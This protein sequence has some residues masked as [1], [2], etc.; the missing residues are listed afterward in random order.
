MYQKILKQFN[1]DNNYLR[2]PYLRDKNFEVLRLVIALDKND[3]E[4]AETYKAKPNGNDSGFITYSDRINISAEWLY[5]SGYIMT[6]G[7]LF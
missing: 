2:C 7:I 1:G 5:N 4:C 3:L 6:K